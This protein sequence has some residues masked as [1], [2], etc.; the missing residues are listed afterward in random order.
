MGMF[1]LIGYLVVLLICFVIGSVIYMATVGPLRV[2]AVPAIKTGYWGRDRTKPKL[3]DEKITQIKITFSDDRLNDLKSRL[4]QTYFF[5][6]LENNNFNYGFRN[7]KLREVV[8]YWN[9]IFDWR[10]Q[11]KMLN[12]YNHF[13]TQIEGISVH[14]VH[15]KSKPK[16]GQ[17]AIPLMMVHGWPGSFYEFYKTIPLLL[18]QANESTDYVFDIVLPS[19]PGYGYSEAP[20]QKGFDASDA[21]RVLQNLMKRLGYE[22]FYIQGGD[23]GSIIVTNMA[24]MYPDSVKGIHTNM[25]GGAFSTA[26]VV[27][28]VITWLFPSLVLGPEEPAYSSI[29]SRLPEMGYAIIQATKPDTVGAALV[30]SPAGLAAYI[31]EKFSSWTNMDNRDHEDGRVTQK[32]TMDELLT[33][34]MIYWTSG[35]ITPSLRFYKEY[36]L[37]L[38]GDSAGST[39]KDWLHV[40]VT[41]PAAFASF[42]NEFIHTPIY[43]TK[44]KFINLIQVSY[45]PRGGHFA[46]FEEPKLVADDVRKFIMSVET[47][48]KKRTTNQK[49][50][51]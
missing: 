19:I 10:K 28:Q 39:V 46:A 14:F 41:V 18:T 8:K 33:N 27:R 16:A 24:A 40:P 3:D 38:T 51:L 15:I 43:V 17:T 1:K 44:L 37:S 32:F 26:S 7:E 2:P 49:K 29:F 25:H 36:I 47:E 35:N 22:R 50:E 20:H 48:A 34:I 42:P 11:E 30:D 13:K 12:S 9:E 23:W 45:M 31:L 4:A 21:A 5:E 6:S